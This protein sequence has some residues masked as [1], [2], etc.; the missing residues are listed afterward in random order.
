MKGL[1]L[2]EL[3]FN[4]IG[5]P[6]IAD[7]FGE[8]Q[9]NI[10]AGLVG[11]GSE[12]FGFDDELSRDHDWGPSF[13]LWLTKKNFETIGL[14]LQKEVQNLPGEFEGF[15]PRQESSW[16]DGRVGVFE[17]EQFYR[18]F[19][20]LDHPPETLVEWRRI[21]EINLAAAT[22]GKVFTDPLGEFTS[23]RD[24]LKSFYPEDVRLKKIAS[25]CMTIA[26]S[27]QYNYPRCVKREDYVAAQ[28]A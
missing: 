25:R 14:G 13:C 19:I 20:G 1:E 23:F 10:A 21:P 5:A 17:I 8:H 15:G 2:C 9:N 12:C 6:M 11:D 18:K 28:W 22:N 4:Q 3:Y 7:K 24:R 16:G 26:Q 27:G